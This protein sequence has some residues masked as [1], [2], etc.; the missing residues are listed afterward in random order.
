MW[1]ESD[2]DANLR[3]GSEKR[4]YILCSNVF[5]HSHSPL[6][7]LRPLEGSDKISA[8]RICTAEF[9]EISAYPMLQE[10][11]LCTFRRKIKAYKSLDWPL[12]LQEI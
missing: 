6:R 12:G 8:R 2:N 10:L 1:R 4:G 7:G 5:V 9:H 3:N 11:V